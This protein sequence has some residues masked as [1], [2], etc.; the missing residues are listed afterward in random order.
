[1]LSWKILPRRL[2]PDYWVT[3]DPG[4]ECPVHRIRETSM[5]PRG[6]M[7]VSDGVAHTFR[8]TPPFSL[9]VLRGYNVTF[10][11]YLRVSN[12]GPTGSS[13]IIRPTG[14]KRGLKVEII[15]SDGCRARAPSYPYMRVSLGQRSELVQKKVLD[16]QFRS[17]PKRWYR[18]QSSR[19]FLL[20][21]RSKFQTRGQFF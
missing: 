7:R 11:V 4:S 2:W 6:S 8:P 5:P 13:W 1:M 10:A 12:I 16:P 9:T 20:L 18:S 3:T 21:N 14:T 15:R 19:S 17:G